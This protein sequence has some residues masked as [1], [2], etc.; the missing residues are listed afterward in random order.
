M[1]L[2]M[3]DGI[4]A[5]LRDLIVYIG[6]K[7]IFKILD[8]Y[9]IN[10]KTSPGEVIQVDIR[11]FATLVSKKDVAAKSVKDELK[12]RDMGLDK[13]SRMKRDET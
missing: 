13:Y 11:C 6:D 4:H 1:K 2:K 10:F 12:S 3:D 5:D 8:A 7:P 9:S